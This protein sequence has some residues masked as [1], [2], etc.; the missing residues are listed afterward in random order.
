MVDLLIR[1]VAVEDVRALDALAA[2]TGSPVTSCCVA[3]FAASHVGES[4]Q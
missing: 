2:H 1:N 3:S 4:S